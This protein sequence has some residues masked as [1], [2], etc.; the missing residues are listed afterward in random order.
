MEAGWYRLHSN[1]RVYVVGEYGDEV[2]VSNRAGIKTSLISKQAIAAKL[3]DF[4]Q[5]VQNIQHLRH[6]PVWPRKE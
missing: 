1:E 6:D 5:E 2:L 3:D 4:P